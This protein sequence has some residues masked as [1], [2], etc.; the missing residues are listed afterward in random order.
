[1]FENYREMSAEQKAQVKAIHKALRA[2]TS[3]RAG[4]LAWA[5]VR[6]FPYRRV[7]RTTRMQTMPDGSIV[8][9]NP[10]PLLYVAKLL[11]AAIPGLEGWF[12]GS[13]S[14][15]ESCPL[16]AWAADPSGAI[17]APGPRPK[18]PFKR[19]VA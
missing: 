4:N 17:P 9:H 7:E 16:I 14:L 1:M 3:T 12:K 19:E 8:N 15:A 18:K 13:Y 5:F 11:A 6:G 10:P 2:E